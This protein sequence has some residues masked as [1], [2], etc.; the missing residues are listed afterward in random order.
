MN[1]SF[2]PPVHLSAVLLIVWYIYT[3]IYMY[4][5][6]IYIIKEMYAYIMHVL[7]TLSL[8][9][10][11]KVRFVDTIIILYCSESAKRTAVDTLANTHTCHGKI[12]DS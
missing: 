6:I 9:L 2:A 10:S 5:Y 7:L 3:Y 11:R 8:S 1:A 4:V 12:D